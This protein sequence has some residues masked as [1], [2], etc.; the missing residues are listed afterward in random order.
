MCLFFNLLKLSHGTSQ[1]IMFFCGEILHGCF[2]VNTSYLSKK[3]YFVEKNVQ[4]ERK[5]DPVYRKSRSAERKSDPFAEK[6]GR[7]SEKA[8][9]KFI[10]NSICNLTI[11]TPNET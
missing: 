3:K 9:K 4:A 6:V 10:R 11:S 8:A 1:I 5:S 2:I 7:R